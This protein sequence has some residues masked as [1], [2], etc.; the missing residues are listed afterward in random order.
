MPRNEP[1][2][3]IQSEE[4]SDGVLVYINQADMHPEE[5]KHTVLLDVRNHQD[6]VRL[7]EF[8]NDR[9]DRP[10]SM[11]ELKY[12]PLSRTLS[13]NGQFR[14]NLLKE[15]YWYFLPF[16]Y[17]ETAVYTAVPE[18]GGGELY[19]RASLKIE[20]SKI[21]ISGFRSPSPPQDKKILSPFSLM[22]SCYPSY[23]T[24]ELTVVDCGHANWNEIRTNG[25]LYIYDTGA[26]RTFNAQKVRE[27][28]ERRAIHL[29]NNTTVIISHWDI[30][31]FHAL[32]AFQPSE[33]SK[34]ERIIAPCNIPETDTYS[35]VITM[36]QDQEI[37]VV[38]V[39]HAS[40]HAHQ[41]QRRSIELVPF[42]R[43]ENIHILRATTGVSSNQTGIVVAVAGSDKV[44]L[45]TGDHHYQKVFRGYERLGFTYSD[46]VMVAPHHGGHAGPINKADSPFVNIVIPLSCGNNQW[47]HPYENT[48]NRIST[49][50]G[51]PPIRT[52][53]HGDLKFLI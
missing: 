16:R 46:C 15:G 10:A 3:P 30:D 33:L 22:L 13:R 49:L 48:L 34:I 31:H 35:R 50:Q 17:L 37:E 6:A 51:S 52:D 36:L 41:W 44:A 25:R 40:R 5:N 45:L 21:N 53:L 8:F 42:G 11:F 43:I 7:S 19:L 47:E 27:I 32:L 9:R 14:H 39:P 28:V 20:G 24:A 2:D 12:T 18:G 29:E 23:S 26:S 1:R 4:R 38:S